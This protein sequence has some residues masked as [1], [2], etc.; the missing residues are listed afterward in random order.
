MKSVLRAFSLLT[1]ALALTVPADLAANNYTF[2]VRQVQMPLGTQ[3]DVSVDQ[4][5]SRQSPL[6]INPHGARFEL[7]AVKSAPLTSYLV[8]TTYVNSYVPV[9]T[10][11]IT[12]EDPYA[13]IPRT[14]ADRPFTVTISVAGMSSDPAAPE[15]ARTVKLLRHV[16]D[17]PNNG[18]GS[19]INRNQ[20]TLYSQGS[21]NNNGTHTLS[22]TVTS[23][24]G[25]DRSKVRGEERFSVYSLQDYQA[26]ESQLNSKFI[27]IWPVAD[28]SVAGISSST[29]V[30]GIAPDVSITLQDLYPESVTYAQ[31]YQG[32]QSLGTQ[33]ALVPG[34]SIVVNGSAPR[35][36]TIHLRNWDSVIET[37]GT[38]TME[39]L[40]VTPFGIDR[41]AHTTFTVA[42]S[43]KLNGAVTSVD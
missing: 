4:E 11:N 3:W 37:D 36:E 27:Q 12:S 25:G 29:V 15:A 19:N 40:T 9:A 20:A 7:W 35:N 2:F 28:C 43:I 30:K 26:P 23:I 17:Y 39:I 1:L 16:Q 18:D 24:P 6:A 33:G 38:W 41:L 5:G 13:V 42:R 14:R 10:V 22:Y 8:D 32:S 31:V 21:L 34:A